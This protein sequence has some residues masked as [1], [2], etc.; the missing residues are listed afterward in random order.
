MTTPIALQL[1]TVRH[2]AERDFTGVLERAA[3]IGFR[4][5]ELVGLYGM[6]A[7]ELKLRLDDLGLEITAG[8]LFTPPPYG[9]EARR[10][11]DEHEKLGTRF[12]VAGLGP[13]SFASLDAVDRAAQMVN[14]AAAMVRER[15]MVL[16][17]HNHDHE[18]QPS[19]AG[20]NPMAELF[21][22]LDPDVMSLLDIYW[23]Q[24]ADVDPFAAIEQLGDRIKHLHVKDGP[25]VR[26]KPQTAV[27]DG[28]VDIP[29]MLAAVPHAAWHVVELDEYDGEMFDAVEKSY[30]YLT[31]NGLSAGREASV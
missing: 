18:F 9:D 26:G 28:Q 27:G 23:L 6:P 31:E 15:G 14:D 2:E 24:T 30:R 22:R 12:I 19:E 21:Q 20:P 16:G 13:D 7:E 25:C 5:V 29:A 1:Y 10:M 11:L 17:Y 8:F 3:A 4:A